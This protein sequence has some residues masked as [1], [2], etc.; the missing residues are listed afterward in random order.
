MLT[1]AFN[2][3]IQLANGKRLKTDPFTNMGQHQMNRKV[4][5]SSKNENECYGQEEQHLFG[6]PRLKKG[7]EYQGNQTTSQLL[8]KYAAQKQ[9][10]QNQQ[11]KQQAPTEYFSK[12]IGFGIGNPTCPQDCVCKGLGKFT[13]KYASQFSTQDRNQ[14]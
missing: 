14:I 8:F 10:T 9:Q 13:N 11:E 5:E 3:I 7:N 1:T 2:G 4:T 12:I 6:P